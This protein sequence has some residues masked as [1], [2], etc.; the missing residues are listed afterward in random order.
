[1]RW[2]RLFESPVGQRTCSSCQQGK[3]SR[4]GGEEAAED[5]GRQDVNEE[6]FQKKN[7]LRKGP[8]DPESTGLGGVSGCRLLGRRCEQ[9]GLSGTAERI[10]SPPL[11]TPLP[12]AL[13][14]PGEGMGAITKGSGPI[15]VLATPPAPHA[16]FS[17]RPKPLEV[18]SWPA[19][20]VALL[21]S[22]KLCT[23]GPGTEPSWASV[24]SSVK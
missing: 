19:S 13:R 8:E 16:G 3:W 21:C 15:S 18:C 4:G 22:A 24:A 20:W 17:G 12:R 1:M 23:L 9:W 14:L 10:S 6:V 2:C 5:I 7:C 11:S